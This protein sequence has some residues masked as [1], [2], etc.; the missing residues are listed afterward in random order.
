MVNRI[1]FSREVTVMS[2]KCTV[3]TVQTSKA[4]WRAYGS[5]SGKHLEATS[6]SSAADALSKW[7]AKA[8]T[9]LL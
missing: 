7:I 8:S 2:E 5:F 9:T 3:W 6:Y 1:P 4:T